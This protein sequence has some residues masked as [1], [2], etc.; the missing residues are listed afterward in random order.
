M[1]SGLQ[2]ANTFTLSEEQFRRVAE[3]CG[4]SGVDTNVYTKYIEMLVEFDKIPFRANMLAS[5]FSWL[6]LA[7]FILFP[8]TFAAWLR[9]DLTVVVQLMDYV[10]QVPLYVIA[11]VCT[12]IGGAGMLWLWWKWRKNYFWLMSSIFIPGLLSSVAGI[13]STIASVYG[14]Q[15]G[16]FTVTSKSALCVTAAVGFVCTLMCIFYRFILIRGLEKQH[17]KEVGNKRGVI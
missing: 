15:Y 6:L 8:G 1:S 11:W 14:A 16:I 9:S 3:R 4:I 2:E 7:G 10:E 17:E 5:F 13:I 12:G